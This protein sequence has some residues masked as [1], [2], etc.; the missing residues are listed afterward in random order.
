[1]NV[2]IHVQ[3]LLDDLQTVYLGD[4]CQLILG[5]DHYQ[6]SPQTAFVSYVQFDKNISNDA[7]LLVKIQSALVNS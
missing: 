1:M 6:P 7:C 3:I 4:Q 2:H 5:I